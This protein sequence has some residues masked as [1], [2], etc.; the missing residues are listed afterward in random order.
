[1]P[2]LQSSSIFVRGL[3][4]HAH[5]GVMPQERIVGADFTL[6]IDLETDITQAALTDT[7]DNTI[8]YADV[9]DVAQREMSQPSALLEH[10]AHRTASALL[11]A[12]PTAS[13]VSIS[14][15]KHNP[16]MHCECMGAGVSLR[17]T[18]G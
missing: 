6:D 15:Q 2:Q 1:M 12:F 14:I 3:R 7:L 18:R 17:L 8:S 5:H 4:V 11:S 16:P 10:V 9:V 13:A